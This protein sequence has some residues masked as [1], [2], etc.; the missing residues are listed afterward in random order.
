[1]NPAVTVVI[2][3]YRAPVLVDCLRSV[4]AHTSPPFGVIVVDDGQLAPSLQTA[5]AQFPRIR[6]LHNPRNL[7]FSASCNRGLE[8]VDTRY[9]VLLNDDTRVTP[10]WLAPLVET[11]ES[12]P[13]IAACQPKLLSATEP[14]RFD[15]GGGAGGYIDR[16]GYT[17]CR[18]RIM[19]TCEQDRGQY[20]NEASLF[21]ACGSALFVRMEAVRRIGLLDLDYHMHFEEIDLCWRLQ[22]AGY[23]I[24]AVPR[25]VVYHHSGYSLPPRS[26]RKTYLNHRNNLVML[27]KNL[28]ARSLV[29]VL[30]VR[31]LL[32]LA[33]TCLY[34]GRR[35]WP[36]VTAPLAALCWLV[37]HPGNLLTRRRQVRART[38]PRYRS[39]ARLQGPGVYRG[40]IAWR[41]YVHGIRRANQLIPEEKA[42]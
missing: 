12:D 37:I 15:Y 38:D 41:Y 33:A 31:I 22:L 36:A 23:R 6:V 19:E 14:G 20:D 39:R 35:N 11:A 3:H 24:R 30:P 1:M 17:F 10:Q 7:G 42:G 16:L 28:D 18:G 27:C 2:P 34:A 40:S 26:F 4:F 25:S 5:Q 21:W 13:S 32:E 29:W 8:E 9:A